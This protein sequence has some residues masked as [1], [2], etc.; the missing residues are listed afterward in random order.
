MR[1]EEVPPNTLYLSTIVSPPLAVI[2]RAFLFSPNAFLSL[3]ILVIQ[4]GFSRL[5]YPD[6]ILDR[7]TTPGLCSNPSQQAGLLHVTD[8]Q[9]TYHA[10]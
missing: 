5:K 9:C 7:A 10:P 2:D 1:L 3:Y 4:H 6:L 8:L